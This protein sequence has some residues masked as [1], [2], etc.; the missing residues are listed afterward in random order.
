MVLANTSDSPLA[1][2]AV[3]NGVEDGDVLKLFSLGAR[4]SRIVELEPSDE[5]GRL[6]MEHDGEPGNLIV[7]GVQFD[8]QGR[9]VSTVVC[10]DPGRA[11]TSRLH[12]SGLAL[13]SNSAPIL[14]LSNHGGLPTKVR[15][16]AQLQAEGESMEAVLPE[17][18]LQAGQSVDLGQELQRFVAREYGLEAPLRG[19]LTVEYST[20]PGTV[21]GH[22]ANVDAS[23]GHPSSIPLQDPLDHFSSAGIYP[24]TLKGGQRT[25]FHVQNMTDRVQSHRW[26]LTSQGEPVYSSGFR[27]LQPGEAITVD[28]GRLSDEGL[29]D[30]QGRIIPPEAAEGQIHWSALGPG[31]SLQARVEHIDPARDAVFT[32]QCED[33]CNHTVHTELFPLSIR[34][35]LGDDPVTFF[36]TQTTEDCNGNVGPQEQVEISHIWFEPPGDIVTVSGDTV[37]CVGPGTAF[38]EVFVPLPFEPGVGEPNPMCEEQQGE[39]TEAVFEVPVEVLPPPTVRI[40]NLVGVPRDGQ[41]KVRVSVMNPSE[42]KVKLSLSR[43]SGSDGEARFM[44]NNKRDLTIRRTTDVFIKGIEASSNAD[45]I[46]L[47]AKAEST[48]LDSG[49]FSVVWVELS[50]KLEGSIASDNSRAGAFVDNLGSTAKL[51]TFQASGRDIR[52]S[53][54]NGVEITGRVTPSDYRGEIVLARD[55]TGIGMC[56]GNVQTLEVNQRQPDTSLAEFRDDDPQSGGS[57][58]RVYDLDAPGLGLNPS[59]SEGTIRRIRQSFE[60]WAAL[61]A[62]EYQTCCLGRIESRFAEMGRKSCFTMTYPTTT[63]H[64]R[65][66]AS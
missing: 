33:C 16:S 40:G 23:A 31:L 3:L 29:S 10:S 32:Y 56:F 2:E 46:R 53:W 5:L 14:A 55:L 47:Q 4:E 30:A 22:A 24:W 58:G 48:V 1:G 50:A 27:K 64:L 21:T 25:F 54:H 38:L 26:Y 34:A 52:D 20:A 66:E 7:H 65:S 43:I 8:S 17:L 11:K 6:A 12:G 51:G 18:M 37:I 62:P 57:A 45:N 42:A 35:V 63:R 19:G 28:I 44:Q 41:A 39:E 9:P 60:Q 36:S 49:V 61:A 13:S 15:V 59:D